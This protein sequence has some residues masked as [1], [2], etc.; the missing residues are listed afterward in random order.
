MRQSCSIRHVVA[1]AKVASYSTKGW[2]SG[3]VSGIV[4]GVKN[5]SRYGWVTLGMG[6]ASVI[7]IGGTAVIGLGT[8][9]SIPELIAQGISGIF[10]MM[11]GFAL[12]LALFPTASWCLFYVD[13]NYFPAWPAFKEYFSSCA[14]WILKL[15]P[16]IIL[17]LDFAWALLLCPPQPL[18]VPLWDQILF[19]FIIVG[20]IGW[21]IAYG[22][23]KLGQ[24]HEG[25]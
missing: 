7:S 15:T 8:M 2:F 21:V 25:S 1:G 14:R 19:G 6:I 20:S 17:A 4:Q 10:T 18:A 23:C 16:V 13:K 11:I 3:G 22:L 12:T 24:N 5:S 9:M